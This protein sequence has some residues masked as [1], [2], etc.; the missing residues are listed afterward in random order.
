[1]KNLEILR[2]SRFGKAFV[3]FNGGDV[4]KPDEK[5]K[6]AMTATFGVTGYEVYMMMLRLINV[7]SIIK[8]SF[9]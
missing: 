4:K 3:T 7:S 9:I 6:F 8:K 5:L 2:E 1:M